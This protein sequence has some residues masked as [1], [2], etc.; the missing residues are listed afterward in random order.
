VEEKKRT[1]KI[2][3]R[4]FADGRLCWGFDHDNVDIHVNEWEGMLRQLRRHWQKRIWGNG[5]IPKEEGER[6][7]I[8]IGIR[9]ADATSRY[10]RPRRHE[11]MGRRKPPRQSRVCT[12]HPRYSGLLVC[13][14]FVPSRL[15]Q[16]VQASH[17]RHV[18][19]QVK[20]RGLIIPFRDGYSTHQVSHPSSMPR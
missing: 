6:R 5:I 16:A 19:V 18:Y 1:D 9:L 4:G 15:T 13:F 8:R 10:R 20:L 14:F 11:D 12:P 3:T 2:T 7:R 17:R